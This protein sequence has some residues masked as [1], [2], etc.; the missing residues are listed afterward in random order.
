MLE[1][2]TCINYDGHNINCGNGK[3]ITLDLDHDKTAEII[4]EHNKTVEQLRIATEALK[5]ISDNP[6]HGQIYTGDP[7]RMVYVEDYAQEVLDTIN[8]NTTGGGGG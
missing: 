6:H 3:V 8:S 4:D 1:R 5:R 2:W 7:P